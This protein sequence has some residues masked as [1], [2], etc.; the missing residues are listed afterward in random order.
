MYGSTLSRQDSAVIATIQGLFLD[1]SKYRIDKS[2]E[3]FVHFQQSVGKIMVQLVVVIKSLMVVVME[4]RKYPQL[5]FQM[6]KHIK[7]PEF[8]TL[9]N[10]KWCTAP[11]TTAVR[12]FRGVMSKFLLSVTL[13]RQL[14]LSH[15][16]P[17]C[18]Y[19]LMFDLI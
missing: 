4:G 14:L 18:P 12:R 9:T 17:K 11:H 5:Q 1:A 2:C 8:H 7:M 10:R 19:C 6:L 3:L 13:I 16:C 15:S